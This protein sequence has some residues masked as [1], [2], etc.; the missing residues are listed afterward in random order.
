MSATE[1][2]LIEGALFCVREEVHS[3]P[4]RT[5]RLKPS[6]TEELSRVPRLFLEGEVGAKGAALLGWLHHRQFLSCSPTLQRGLPMAHN[7]LAACAPPNLGC[8][9]CA[10]SG[11]FTCEDGQLAHMDAC[12]QG[13]CFDK[14]RGHCVERSLCS[15]TAEGAASGGTTP[16]V[17][18]GKQLRGHGRPQG[19]HA[20]LDGASEPALPRRSV[21]RRPGA[22]PALK[23]WCTHPAL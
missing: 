11:Y 21:L 7:A 16:G 5:F 8:C 17:Y 3:R 18:Q 1:E 19:A 15:C 12:P 22:H 20:H 14:A 2:P 9:T 6:G 4:R 10:C 13:L 23:L